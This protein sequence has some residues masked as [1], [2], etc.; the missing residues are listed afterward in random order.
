MEVSKTTGMKKCVRSV[1]WTVFGIYCFILI[2]IL[3]LS[4]GANIHYTYAQYFRQFTNFIPFRTIV[5]YIDRYNNGFRNLSVVNLLGNF[6]LFTPMGM[7]LPCVA[8]ELNRF[9]KVTL[10]VLVMVVAVEITQGILRVGSVDIDDVL[11]NVIGAIIGYGM[12]KI[13]FV[14]KFF[15]KINLIKE[16]NRISE[17]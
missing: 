4:R 15:K 16:E 7:L 8:T 10:T 17:E 13:P 11:F 9:W 1:L 2:Y 3:F 12:I 14:F 5:E 6:I